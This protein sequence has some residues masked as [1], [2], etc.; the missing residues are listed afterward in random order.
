MLL[1][2]VFSGFCHTAG[3][4]LSVRNFFTKMIFS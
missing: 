2:Q 4:E 3:F 1:R